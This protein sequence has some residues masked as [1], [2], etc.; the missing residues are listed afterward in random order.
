MGH[1]GKQ[2]GGSRRR[3]QDPVDADNERHSTRGKVVG[4]KPQ[5]EWATQGVR[6]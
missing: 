3:L 6:Y 4:H 1:K 5:D 2:P